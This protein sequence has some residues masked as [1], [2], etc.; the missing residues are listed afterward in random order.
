M[1]YS[2]HQWAMLSSNYHCSRRVPLHD[3][4]M[5]SVLTHLHLRVVTYSRSQCVSSLGRACHNRDA[6][7]AQPRRVLNSRKSDS[8]T[9]KLIQ[10][11]ELVVHGNE[12]AK[13]LTSRGKDCRD[14]ADDRR[15]RRH[16]ARGHGNFRNL[17]PT[18]M[19][20]LNLLSR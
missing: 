15:E 11:V 18:L 14:T 6:H 9:R 3:L 20:S 5:A 10:L 19:F 13:S 8:S 12:S 4:I 2:V 16:F 17:L 7:C 1:L